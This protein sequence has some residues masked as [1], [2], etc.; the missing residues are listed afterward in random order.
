MEG[1]YVRLDGKKLTDQQKVNLLN[2]AKE[3]EKKENPDFDPRKHRI[4]HGIRGYLEPGQ[5]AFSAGAF[6]G[7]GV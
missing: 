2:Q 6:E 5:K 7:K 4:T 3:E 1:K